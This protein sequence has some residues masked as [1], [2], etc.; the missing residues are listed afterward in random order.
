[1]DK[2]ISNFVFD[3]GFYKRLGLKHVK[4]LQEHCVMYYA[5]VGAVL[6]RIWSVNNQATSPTHPPPR[7][8]Q[9]KL[10]VAGFLFVTLGCRK[11]NRAPGRVLTLTLIVLREIGIGDTHNYLNLITNWQ[12]FSEGFHIW[13]IVQT[14]LRH[15]QNSH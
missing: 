8:T 14:L 6:Y 3:L 9:L 7:V 1:M 2:N 12:D 11:G 15:L 4:T 5:E 13:N 10:E